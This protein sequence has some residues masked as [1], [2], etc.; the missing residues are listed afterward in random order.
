MRY[1]SL[2]STGLWVSAVGFGGIPIQR[3]D[4]DM[5]VQLVNRSLNLGINFFDTARGGYNISNVMLI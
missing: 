4:E 3:V 2:G 5:A 1:R